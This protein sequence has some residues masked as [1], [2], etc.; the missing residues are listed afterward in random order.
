MWPFFRLV[1]KSCENFDINDN[2]KIDFVCG[3]YVAVELT[4]NSDFI[5]CFVCWWTENLCYN[6]S[7]DE[8]VVLDCWNCRPNSNYFF[9]GV[10]VTNARCCFRITMWYIA[11]RHLFIAAT[12]SIYS[13]IKYSVYCHLTGI[14]GDNDDR[15]HD[16]DRQQ[17][18]GH[19]LLICQ[20]QKRR[21]NK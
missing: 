4:L 21:C 18:C 13:F 17:W 3:T 7:T 6:L 15:Q 10:L 11:A 16:D 1:I 8:T 19:Y 2:M 20:S 14:N 5:S 9:Q 12:W